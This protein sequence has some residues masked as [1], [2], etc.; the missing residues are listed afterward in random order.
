MARRVK[1]AAARVRHVRDDANQLQRVHEANGI[2]ASA[3]DAERE[4]AAGQAAVELLL[5]ERVIFAVGQSRVID[6]RDFRVRFQIFRG[7]ERV[8]AVARHAQM[9]R[10]QPDAATESN[11]GRA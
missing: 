2:F 4:H 11:R 9:Q 6:P 7:G 1:N 5:R 8:F 10:F 3:L